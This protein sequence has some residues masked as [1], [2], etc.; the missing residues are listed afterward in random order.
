MS[1]L[2][3]AVRERLREFGITLEVQRQAAD[4]HIDAIVTLSREGQ[5]QRYAAE[6]RATMTLGST[7]RDAQ[8]RF[9]GAV[10]PLLVIGHRISPRSADAFRAAGIQFADALGNAFLAFGSVLIDVRGRTESAAASSG[11]YRPADR[12]P[13]PANL[14]SSRRAQVI[15]VLL[16][17][18]ELSRMTVREIATASGVSTGQ[19]HDTLNRLQQ[20]GFLVPDSKRLERTDRKS[21]V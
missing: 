3:D 7:V 12:S 11:A 9:E 8:D 6:A 2:L 16:A 18:P 10:D 13:H 15:L 17:W 19:A 5:S 4:A 20:A 21:V 1:A 14:F